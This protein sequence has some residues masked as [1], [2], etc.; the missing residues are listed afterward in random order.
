MCFSSEPK[1]QARNV[2][3]A[4]ERDNSLL[5]PLSGSLLVCWLEATNFSVE[6][7]KVNPE[8]SS[9]IL[10]MASVRADCNLSL[11]NRESETTCPTAPCVIA[12]SDV[13]VARQERK[14]HIYIPMGARLFKRLAARNKI[15]C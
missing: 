6:G 4:L 12:Y 14:A 11:G 9:Y 10:F 8:Q 7:L 1:H 15:E 2:P 13:W 3:P 5:E